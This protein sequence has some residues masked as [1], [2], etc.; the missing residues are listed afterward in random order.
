MTGIKTVATRYTYC[1][2]LHFR[3]TLECSLWKSS[4][5][6]NN[7]KDVQAIESQNIVSF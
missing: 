6:T 2:P 4:V 7:I 3:E 1:N 5:A